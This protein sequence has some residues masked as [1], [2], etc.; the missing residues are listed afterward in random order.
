MYLSDPD[1]RESVTSVETICADGTVIDPFIILPGVNHLHKAFEDLF[2]NT[3]I[4]MSESGY[5][6]DD[7][8]LEYAQHFSV[9]S[10]SVQGSAAY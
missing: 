2:G 3:L 7:L 10:T 4:G 1:N 5:S 6:N 9:Q 8:N